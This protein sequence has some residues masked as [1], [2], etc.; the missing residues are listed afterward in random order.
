MSPLVLE[1]QGGQGMSRKS[2]FESRPSQDPRLPTCSVR[3]VQKL[4]LQFVKTEGA[5][6]GTRR[7]MFAGAIC[8]HVPH[9]ATA[10]TFRASRDPTNVSCNVLCTSCRL[11]LV[12]F[13][14]RH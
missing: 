14:A 13:I 4:L 12:C 7:T 3:A 8:A 9:E 6:Q 11:S 5:E 2:T 1:R 10:T